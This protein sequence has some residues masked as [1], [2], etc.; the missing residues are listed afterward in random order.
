MNTDT[1]PSSI[2]SLA[3]GLTPPMLGAAY[4]ADRDQPLPR[5]SP[6]SGRVGI[7]ETPSSTVPAFRRGDVANVWGL[8]VDAMTMAESLDAIGQMIE[9]RVPRYIITANLNYAMLADRDPS[10]ETVTRDAAMI[11]ADGQPLVWRSRLAGGVRLPERVTGSELIHRLAERAA[12][13]QWRVFFLG[14]APGVAQRCADRLSQLYTGLPVAGTYAPPF[15]VSS[16]AERG[17]LRARIRDARPDILLVAFGQ[18]KGEK[19][20]HENYRFLEVPVSLQ[21]GASFDFVAGTARR[22]PKMLQKMGLEW[23]HRCATEPR[24]L[25]PRYASNAKFLAL[26]LIR[27]WHAYVND[28]YGYGLP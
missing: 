8:P 2:E 4:R 14:A 5:L 20:I 24:R 6:T 9:D 10:L 17:E 12:Q 18:P 19:W 15:R 26:S 3:S 11:L 22:A 13:S 16:E 28:R 1:F 7:G 27:D 25:V 23:A 21:V